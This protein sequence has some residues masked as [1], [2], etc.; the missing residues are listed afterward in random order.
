MVRLTFL[1]LGLAALRTTMGADAD[2]ATDVDTL[3]Q[4]LQCVNG[5]LDRIRATPTLPAALLSASSTMDCIPSS[6]SETAAAFKTSAESWISSFHAQAS[7]C[8]AF[9]SASL[10]EIPTSLPD[11]TL[12]A[13]D[14]GTQP[15]RTRS[16]INTAPSVT[17]TGATAK[18]TQSSD[19]TGREAGLFSS[20]AVVIAGLMIAVL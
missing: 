14:A 16:V 20:F 5:L 19:A 10:A 6:L 1:C 9:P 8:K 4:N 17:N 18:S 11:I 12:C 13:G 3:Q 2:T 7:S 15:A